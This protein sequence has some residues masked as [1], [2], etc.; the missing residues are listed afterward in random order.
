M[1]LV[2]YFIV[3]ATVNYVYRG[4]RGAEVIP[5][6]A[7]WKDLP[8]LIKVCASTSTTVNSSNF[9]CNI[10]VQEISCVL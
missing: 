2:V 1:A 8:F 9:Y 7:L 4:A 6:Y 10:I 5:N 3:G